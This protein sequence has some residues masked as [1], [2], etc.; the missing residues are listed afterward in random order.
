VDDFTTFQ[1]KIKKGF[2]NRVFEIRG[3]RTRRL[4][5]EQGNEDV[6]IASAG[7]LSLHTLLSHNTG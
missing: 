5:A 7:G 6:T 1:K 2:E 3:G 4:R